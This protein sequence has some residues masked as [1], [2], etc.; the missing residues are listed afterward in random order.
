MASD[1][2]RID[3]SSKESIHNWIE[4][5][6]LTCTPETTIGLLGSIYFAS[7]TFCNA[8]I[9][10]MADRVGRKWPFFLSI[11]IEMIAYFWIF[12]S[13]DIW[14]IIACYFVIGCCAAGRM[15][16]SIPYMNEF[17]PEDRQNFATTMM[18][19]HDASIMIVQAIA[20]SYCANW[21][22]VHIGGLCFG[23]FNL[24]AI[25]VIPESPQYYYSKGQFDEARAI[26]NQIAYWNGADTK[27]DKMK[28]DT[29]VTK[30]KDDSLIENS[31]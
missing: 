16:I 1:K 11:L 27:F 19:C 8:I 3:Y 12:F 24:C 20:Y 5:L 18:N 30:D 6:D 9:P 15:G 25:F 28:F 26:L 31:T 29:E 10:A 14:Q 21:V 4:H 13:K 17:L 23:C 7:F 22:P 2:W